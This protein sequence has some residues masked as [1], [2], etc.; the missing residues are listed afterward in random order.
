MWKTLGK[1]LP[2]PKAEISDSVMIISQNFLM[3]VV[4]WLKHEGLLRPPQDKATFTANQRRTS[5]IQNF[6]TKE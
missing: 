1:L 6:S 4:L 5:K 2:A 3:L